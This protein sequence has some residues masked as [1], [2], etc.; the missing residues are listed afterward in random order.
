MGIGKGVVSML[1]SHNLPERE[2]D[3]LRERGGGGEREKHE[4]R[5]RER[6]RY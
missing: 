2:K 4:E 3:I 5:E 1:G 6:K